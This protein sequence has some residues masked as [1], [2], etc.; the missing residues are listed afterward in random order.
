[1]RW[2]SPLLRAEALSDAA[3]A[4]VV[5]PQAGYRVSDK[6]DGFS[7]LTP[8]E[9]LQLRLE[10]QIAR[11]HAQSIRH[12]IIVRCGILFT[13]VVSGL[14]T[15]FSAIGLQI[16]LSVTTSAVTGVNALMEQNSYES[17]LL[18]YNITKNELQRVRASFGR[19]TARAGCGRGR[20]CGLCGAVRALC[21]RSVRAPV[22]C[23]GAV[24][25]AVPLRDRAGQPAEVL[26]PCARHRNR[27]AHGERERVPRRGFPSSGLGAATRR[28]FHTRCRCEAHNARR[29]GW[30]QAR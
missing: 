19:P 7:V 8:D 3:R 30:P 29:A 1:M 26:N 10:P 17:N 12:N 11:C 25:V 4:C 16:F 2:R 15:L 9:Y 27:T 23:A 20:L 14:G 24:L 6:D 5:S 21:Q 13:I 28:A 18:T 22:R